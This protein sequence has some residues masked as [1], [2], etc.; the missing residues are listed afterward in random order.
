MSGVRIAIIAVIIGA[1]LIIGGIIT[2][3]TDLNSRR[4]PLNIDPIPGAESYGN[5]VSD[6]SND[7]TFYFRVPDLT[8]DQ[9]VAYYQG[10][11]SEFSGGIT[12]CVR[13]PS[14]GEVPLDPNVED[15]IPFR[16]DC[17]FDRSGIGTTQYTNVRIFPG[18][19]NEEPLLNNF[20]YTVIGY[21]QVWQP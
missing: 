19:P 14:Q 9:V 5:A 7:R 3:Q 18:L 13:T 21:Q 10:K 4:S 20:G 6:R 1:V 15:S 16:F 2:Y 11:L 17:L 8:V 12:R